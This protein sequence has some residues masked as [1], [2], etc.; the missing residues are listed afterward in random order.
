MQTGLVFNVQRF[1]LHD[2][3]GLRTTVFVKGCPL[4]CAWCHN[5]ESQS[6]SIEFVRL[7]HR[8]M[9]CGRC[10]EADLASRVVRGRD[11]RDVDLCPTGALQTVGERIDAPSLVRTLLRDRIFFD[12]SHGGVTFSGGEPLA[13]AGFVTEAMRRL[14]AEGV[15]TALDTCGFGS[16][17]D[18]RAAAA[19]SNTVLFDLKLMDD[20][21]HQ[22]ATGVSNRPILENLRALAAVHADIWIRIPIVPG[23]TDDEANVEA[24][25]EFVRPLAGVTRVDLLP[26]HP[27]GE[28]KFARAGREYPLGGTPVPDD[29]RL[30]G[31]AARVRATGLAVTIGGHA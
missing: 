1:S 2:G 30:E 16:W 21:R 8:C 6:P 7:C 20:G 29:A 22:A 26:Y 9:R 24:V 23:I 18:L 11:E 31:L 17:P 3:P 19:A 25:A 10:S 14:Q 27:T 15:H 13:Q 4:A 5:P 12:E 28:A